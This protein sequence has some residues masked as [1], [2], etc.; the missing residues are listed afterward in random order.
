VI[1]GHTHG[2][3]ISLVA[4][5]TDSTLLHDLTD[6]H[7]ITDLVSHLG[8]WLDEGRFDEAPSILIDDVTVDTP[9][10]HAEGI[11]HVIAQA[12]R[13]HQHD[14]LQHVITNVLIDLD[15][16][17]ARVRANLV[18]TFADDAVTSQQGERYR[19]EAVRTPDGWRLSR[20]EVVPVWKVEP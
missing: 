3:V 15:G 7:E 10:G 8:L 16:D 17:R 13:N 2:Y 20:V 4:P 18:V 5:M 9:G 1:V 19:F 12:R 11:E 14:H 6:R